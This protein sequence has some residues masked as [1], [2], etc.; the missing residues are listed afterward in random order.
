MGDPIFSSDGLYHIFRWIH[1]MAGITWIGF[2]Y[3]LNFVQGAFFAETDSNTKSTA[4]RQLLPKVLWWFR[5][6][7]AFTFF[8]GLLMLWLKA[9][10]AGDHSIYT[11]TSWG[12]W[13]LL[14]TIFGTLMAYNVWFEIWPRQKIVIAS[15]NAVA[16]G[17]QADP[18]AADAGARAGVFSRTNVLFS[19]PMLFLMGAASH[20]PL[21]N[22]GPDAH[23]GMTFGLFLIL[24]G[25]LE[26][27]AFKGKLGPLTKV[28]GVIHMGLLLT[29]VVYGLVRWAL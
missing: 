20:L 23:V 17:G 22:V 18:R 26:L 1:F 3:Y 29:L 19:I 15:A 9:H 2:L 7:A 8:S 13:I 4:V 28:S 21:P 16:S 24:V 14:G 27:N 25:L 12:I 11:Q 10:Q 6:G 5:W